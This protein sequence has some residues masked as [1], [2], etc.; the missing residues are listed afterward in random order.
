MRPTKAP[1]E[2]MLGPNRGKRNKSVF[3]I[4]I[5]PRIQKCFCIRSKDALELRE[6]FRTKGKPSDREIASQ[7]RAAREL[8]GSGQ[9]LRS[10]DPF[11]EVRAARK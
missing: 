8:E 3:S 1:P 10:Q 11:Y 6:R 5:F 7:I 4:I 2:T 9:Q